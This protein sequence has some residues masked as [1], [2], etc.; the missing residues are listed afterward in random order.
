MFRFAQLLCHFCH[1]CR[2]RG[3]LLPVPRYMRCQSP[4]SSSRLAIPVGILRQLEHWSCRRRVG[5]VLGVRGRDGPAARHRATVRRAVHRHR[6]MPERGHV[7]QR[8]SI[9]S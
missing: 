5:M 9:F 4:R 2:C 7:L 3:M 8:E 1:V 6:V